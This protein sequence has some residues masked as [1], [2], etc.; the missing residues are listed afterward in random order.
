MSLRG[1]SRVTVT[2]LLLLVCIVSVV[3][4]ARAELVDG[5]R[6]RVQAGDTVF[7]IAR[8]IYPDDRARQARLRQDIL[9]LNKVEFLQGAPSLRIDTLLRLPDYVD[10][11]AEVAPSTVKKQPETI[12][13]STKTDPAPKGDQPA[14][15]QRW[16]VRRGDTLYSIGR[17]VFPGN[18]RRQAQLRED[19]IRLNPVAFARG[20][21][22]MEVG[23]VLLL[24]DYA[25][26]TPGPAPAT[27]PATRQAQ[28]E[29]VAKTPTAKTTPQPESIEKPEPVP[30]PQPEPELVSAT[31]APEQTRESRRAQPT[32][33]RSDRTGRFVAS[34]GGS[35][36]G[37]VLV[38]VDQWPDLT[39]GFGAQ[40]RFGYEW[41]PRNGS[42]FRASLGLHYNIVMDGSKD[43]SFQN[44]YWQL[45]YQYRKD[46]LL[47]GIGIVADN[48][49]TLDDDG[50]T[51]DFDSATGLTLYVEQAGG[52]IV[53]GWGA[54][55]T[56]LEIEV[57][58]SGEDAN[59]SRLEIY[60]SWIL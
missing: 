47:Y 39:A 20:A 42:G 29:P 22:A 8:A 27:A 30:E 50:D 49:A 31:Q 6:W 37:D 1:R 3:P 51:T 19:I 54:A 32:A 14:T 4:F 13:R 24:P 44:T 5:N 15:G 53:Q 10:G 56:I 59:A 33:S 34:L 7:G 9:R 41:M 28:P 52:G 2:G 12:P 11:S 55:A 17:A 48:G 16:I 36:G 45:A 60:Y 23:A 38:R 35:A 25:R 40:G 43:A 18:S 58:D 26:L 21:S 46:S 57:E